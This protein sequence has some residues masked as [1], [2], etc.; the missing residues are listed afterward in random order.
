MYTE[1]YFQAVQREGQ[2]CSEF[3]TYMEELT[4]G[5]PGPPTEEQEV[6]NLM[7]KVL[8]YL[9]KKFFDLPEPPNTRKDFYDR[10]Y[11][12]EA[13]SGGVGKRIASQKSSKPSDPSNRTPRGDDAPPPQNRKRKQSGNNGGS[14]ETKRRW[15][16]MP[17]LS[18][19]EFKRRRDG[20]LC[21]RC[22]KP[23]HRVSDCK[24]PP[25]RG[26]E[27]ATVSFPTSAVRAFRSRE[28]AHPTVGNPSAPR[29]D[30][31]LETSTTLHV[32]DEEI[33][34][35]ALIDSAADRNAIDRNFINKYVQDPF[36]M[37]VGKVEMANGTYD[38]LYG[39]FTADVTITDATGDTH[40]FS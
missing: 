34:T 23:G 27:S 40:T 39:V 5:L 1:K 10:C 6:C 31:A 28:D 7:V 15:P 2:S 4:Q 30:R 38:R 3:F 37:P 24:S 21:L 9:R 17:A 20:N 18:D 12:F 16:T 13:A 33:N 32:D 35:D 19:E 25:T 14:G 11:R 8:P 36:L 26:D 22:A 29:Q